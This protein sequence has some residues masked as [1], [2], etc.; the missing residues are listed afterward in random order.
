MSDRIRLTLTDVELGLIN[1]HCHLAP[2]LRSRL[3]ATSVRG[4]TF[5]LTV[6]EVSAL[7]EAVADRLQRAGFDEHWDVNAEGSALEGIIDKLQPPRR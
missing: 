4:R 1:E 6:A 7:R 2:E 3:E 5:E